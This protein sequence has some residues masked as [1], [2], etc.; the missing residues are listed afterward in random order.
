MWL[1]KLVLRKFEISLIFVGS[2]DRLDCMN[3]KL[4]DDNNSKNIEDRR[5]VV[6]LF[7]MH[8]TSICRNIHRCVAA[9]A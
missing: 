1:R 4:L 2:Q 3:M 8:H 7:R 6:K 9:R 5:S